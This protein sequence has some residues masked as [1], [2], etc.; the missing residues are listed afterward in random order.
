MANDPC[1][2]SSRDAEEEPASVTMPFGVMGGAYQPCGHVR[3]MSNMVDFGMDPQTAIDA[4]RCFAADGLLKMERGYSSNV[5]QELADIGHKVVVPD[6][7]LGGAQ[8]I[9]IDHDNGTLHGASDPRKDGARWATETLASVVQTFVQSANAEIE[10]LCL[11]RRQ[12]ALP[13]A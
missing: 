1:T 4:P 12:V 3:F 8:A 13:K 11:D 5:R 9:F 6:E 2:R 7:P 10:K